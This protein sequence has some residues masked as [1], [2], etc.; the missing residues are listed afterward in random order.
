MTDWRAL[1]Y[2]PDSEGDD[3]DGFSPS[4][5]RFGADTTPH[6][7]TDTPTEGLQSVNERA[8]QLDVYDFPSSSAD[9]DDVPSSARGRGRGRPPR[10]GRG[11]KRL[12]AGGSQRPR[13]QQKIEEPDE[14]ADMA[15]SD[16]TSNSLSGLLG[17]KDGIG[18]SSPLPSSPSRLGFLDSPRKTENQIGRSENTMYSTIL[19]D[20]VP[21]PIR[22]SSPHTNIPVTT[23]SRPTENQGVERFDLEHG[24]DSEPAS[25]NEHLPVP[26][27]SPPFLS[28]RLA[29]EFRIDSPAPPTPVSVQSIFEVRVP[30]S[31]HTGLTD[32]ATRVSLSSIGNSDGPQITADDFTSGVVRNLR[33]RKPIQLNPYMLEEQQYKSVWKSRGLRPVRYAEDEPILP[34]NRKPAQ[35]DSQEG[36]FVAPEEEEEETQAATV[37][38]TQNFQSLGR[39]SF[40]PGRSQDDSLPTLDD[41]FGRSHR[42]KPPSPGVRSTATVGKRQKTKQP[43]ELTARSKKIIAAAKASVARGQN[44]GVAATGAQ[45]QTPVAG[46]K[47][48][49]GGIFDLDSSDTDAAVNRTPVSAPRRRVIFDSDESETEGAQT[50]KGRSRAVSEKSNSSESSESSETD[51]GRRE[52]EIHRFQK[53]ARG[54][55]PAS[56]LR[57]NQPGTQDPASKRNVPVPNSPEKRPMVKGMAQMRIRTRNSPPAGSMSN[58]LNLNSSAGENSDDDPIPMDTPR[59]QSRVLSNGTLPSTAAPR[60]STRSYAFEDNGFDRMLSRSTGSKSAT[61]KPRSSKSNSKKLKQS[62]L[63]SVSLS[64]A[65][66]RRQHGSSKPRPKPAALSVVDA[67]KRYRETK[68]SKPPQFMRIAERRVRKKKNAGRQLPDRKVV[69]IDRVFDET[70]GE[71]TLARWKRAKLVRTSS[72]ASID[73]S[74]VASNTPQAQSSLNTIPNLSHKPSTYLQTK[75]ASNSTYQPPPQPRLKPRVKY[76]A[77]HQPITIIPGRGQLR[78]EQIVKNLRR[79]AE[80]PIEVDSPEP[81]SSLPAPRNASEALPSPKLPKKP[82]IVWINK[83]PEQLFVNA[84]SEVFNKDGRV[85]PRPSVRRRKAHIPKRVD[86]HKSPIAFQPPEK[87]ATRAT[88]VMDI[89]SG[90]DNTLSFENMPPR[91]TYFSRDF[92]VKVPT[93]KTLFHQSTFLGSGCLSKA[94]ATSVGKLFPSSRVGANRI[95]ILAQSLDW[96][97]YD[98]SVSAQAESLLSSIFERAEHH[99]NDRTIDSYDDGIILDLRR[100]FRYIV[101][102]LSGTIHFSDLIDIGS[103][104]ARFSEIISEAV[105][106]ASA[107][108]IVHGTS[109]NQLASLF[110]LEVYSYAAVI[111]HQIAAILGEKDG[112]QSH[113][114]EQLQKEVSERLISILMAIGPLKLQQGLSRAFQN[115]LSNGK[116]D[117]DAIYLESWVIAYHT[118]LSIRQGNMAQSLFWDNINTSFGSSLVHSKDVEI[119]ENA[120]RNIYR[121]L[122]P[123]MIDANG[124]LAPPVEKE[125]RPDNWKFVK[126]VLGRA[127]QIYT[128][129]KPKAQHTANGYIKALYSRCL[130]LVRDWKW[131]ISETIAST[132]Y[133][134]FAKRGLHN[135]KNEDDRS[136]AFIQH[137]DDP[138]FDSD[139]TETCF[140]TFLKI[141]ALGLERLR[142][143]SND[144]AVGG[145]VARLIP[146]HGRKFPK[147]EALQLDEYN[148]LRNHHDLLA[149][150]YYGGARKARILHIVRPLVDPEKS[151]SK[152]CSLSLRT[153]SNILTCELADPQRDTDILS[154]LMKWHSHIMLT[155]M[156][157]HKDLRVHAEQA[158]KAAFDPRNIDAINNNAQ[159]NKRE[160]ESILFSGLGLLAVALKNKYC[161]LESAKTLLASDTMKAIFGMPNHLPQR[162]VA[163]AVNIVSAHVEVCMKFGEAEV[164]EESQES[165]AGFEGFENDEA[166]K[167]AAKKLLDEIYDP[168]FGLINNYFAA[169]EKHLD[170]VLIPCIQVWIEL[171]A[172]LVRCE[173]KTWG[174]YFNAYRKSWFSMIDTDNKKIYSVYYVANIMK[175]DSSVYDSHKARILEVWI[176]S[177]VERDT[178]LKF[179]HELTSIVFNYDLSNKLFAGMPFEIDKEAEEYRISL[180]DFKAR[181]LSLL[182]TLLENMQTEMS[183]LQSSGDHRQIASVKNE[184]SSM[185]QDLMSAMRKNYLETQS[186]QQQPAAN[187]AVGIRTVKPETTSTYVTFCQKV[188]ELLQQYT[189]DICAIDKFFVDS[190]TFPLPMNDPTYVTSKLKGYTLRL[191]TNKSGWWP[192]LSQ[193]FQNTCSRVAIEGQQGY[194]VK[195]I[196]EA[197]QGENQSERVARTEGKRTLREVC[198]LAMF[199]CYVERCMESITTLVLAVP[200]VKVVEGVVGGLVTEFDGVEE[201]RSMDGHIANFLVGVLEAVVKALEGCIERGDAVLGEPLALYMLDLLARVVRECDVMVNMLH[202][203]I[204]HVSDELPQDLLKVTVRSFSRLKAHLMN[205]PLPEKLDMIMFQS[206]LPFKNERGKY[207]EQYQADL[208][209]WRV[210]DGGD[211]VLNKLGVRKVI[212]WK[213]LLMDEDVMEGRRRLLERIDAV[214][215]NA[216]FGVCGAIV[217]EVDEVVWERAQRPMLGMVELLFGGGEGGDGGIAA[218][219]TVD[220][221]VFFDMDD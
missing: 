57:L 28:T 182:S 202:P 21:S 210:G 81:L 169:T 110:R 218:P 69:K 106:K 94:L 99:L 152:V 173:L 1:G 76:K 92:D 84:R 119:F 129:L 121:L 95:E 59:M 131:C 188:V 29:M 115:I 130:I 64:T 206:D 193:F 183:R 184:Y 79:N 12:S 221:S 102:Y 200:I 204:T 52:Q 23:P 196:L 111:S 212:G 145:I 5:P 123:T 27:S 86:R 30:F 4:P 62:K 217:R 122:P 165:W 142:N 186:H 48:A 190:V 180:K 80:D 195:Q 171:A 87:T 19:G 147:E 194:F 66:S 39:E 199:G 78:M 214:L 2:V 88:E 211:L 207:R 185:L 125:V 156:R 187:A 104:A 61:S 31:A 96:A 91:G 8:A 10:R 192:Q 158:R 138:I 42:E 17:G 65:I 98:E 13:K 172:L 60:S 154:G 49:R 68:G 40:E 43:F 208:R 155:T 128:S 161:D 148:T 136:P 124:K 20:D 41:L 15:R 114:I 166:R 216:S 150:I 50:P 135:L 107:L 116:L 112:S 75:L 44:S 26:P 56:Y 100:L 118:S 219:D 24:P 45:P 215:K 7:A 18:I 108:D 177:L 22:A 198:A 47:K 6:P 90:D 93:S 113:I 189:T 134:F 25:Q 74:G 220:G 85:P 162:L 51:P 71:D 159:T 16:R 32:P 176:S 54:V 58:P 132:L 33:E 139:P 168:L 175:S 151:H 209:N 63:T 89:D 203:R 101:E 133:N 160:L 73:G 3:D 109:S 126:D 141:V 83:P 137:L 11:A 117:E 153:W 191:Q 179:Q 72:V 38:A 164:Q 70:D 144:K 201:G 14:L 197:F 35:D 36:D 143:S 149:A 170:Q 181:R 105:S 77:K 9:I 97:V 34:S 120:W 55:L 127:L 163:E 103:F 146:N 53:R 213:H 67:C 46:S 178:L 174:D 37:Q 82:E 167:D 157:L 140:S 205:Q